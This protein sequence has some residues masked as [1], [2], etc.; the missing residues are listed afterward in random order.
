MLDIEK[1]GKSTV[2]CNTDECHPEKKDE[3]LKN[4]T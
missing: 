4:G 2:L 1:K 3:P